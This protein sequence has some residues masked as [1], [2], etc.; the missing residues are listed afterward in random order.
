MYRNKDVSSDSTARRA[1]FQGPD[2]QVQI[3]PVNKTTIGALP[4]NKYLKEDTLIHLMTSL[5]QQ[6][7]QK[8]L[9]I[10]CKHA[11]AEGLAKPNLLLFL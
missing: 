9:R 3:Q 10:L 5:Q 6:T 1:L 8:R 11:N 4:E 7:H 2:H